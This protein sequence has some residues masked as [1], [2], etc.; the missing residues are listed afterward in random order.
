[1]K[2]TDAAAR[3]ADYRQQIAVLREKMRATQSQVEPQEVSDYEFQT[4]EGPTRLSQLFGDH[5]QL[6]VIHNMGASC[7]ACTLWADGFNGVYHHLI[8]RAAFVLATPDPPQAQRKFAASR[9]WKFPL[10]SHAGSSFAAD[11]GFRTES[12]WKPGVS[13]FQRQDGKIVRVAEAHFG[14]GDDFCSV[15]HLF[16]LLPGG[17]GDWWPQVRY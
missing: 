13:V 3:L 11:M 14:P 15:W 6:I 4:P 9:G 7:P 8:R 16:D 10:V 17:A 5:Q 1:M 12:G 2:Y